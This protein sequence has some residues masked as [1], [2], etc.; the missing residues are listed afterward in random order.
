MPIIT[1]TLPV[2][3]KRER[4]TRREFLEYQR[5]LP[6]EDAP[7][8]PVTVDIDKQMLQGLVK[9][10]RTAVKNLIDLALKGR[11][12]GSEG[13]EAAAAVLAQHVLPKGLTEVVALDV[14]PQFHMIEDAAAEIPWEALE[15]NYYCCPNGHR[16]PA[17]QA[18]SGFVLHCEHDD[19]R[20]SSACSKLVLGRHVTHLVPR[21]AR[22]LASGNQFLFIAD[23]TGEL[24]NS[25]N[26][27]QGYCAE[28]LDTLRT[29]L[30]NRG[31]EVL[32][33]QEGNATRSAVLDALRKPGVVGVYYFGHG[34]VPTGRRQQGRLVLCD[35][36][37]FAREIEQA[38]SGASLVFLN[39]CEGAIIG[40]GWESD[41]EQR[42][43]SVAEGFAR[44]GGRVVIGTLWPVVN[45]QAARTAL[46]FFERILTGDCSIGEA[47]MHA[48][49]C[50]YRRYKDEDQPDIS[51]MSYRFF[52]DP[53][54]ILPA[55]PGPQPSP[56]RDVPAQQAQCRV[57][58]SQSQLDRETFAFAF[59][60]A[61]ACAAARRNAQGRARATTTDFLAGLM[62]KGDLTRF[63]LHEL[64]HDPDEA[65]RSVL[66]LP[67]EGSPAAE[68]APLISGRSDLTDELAAVFMA[69]DGRAQ[70]TGRAAE[71]T[72]ICERHMLDELLAAGA[73]SRLARL[74]LPSSD[75]MEAQLKAIAEAGE[76]DDNGAI[77]LF[78]LDR[79]ARRVMQAAHGYAQ[80]R[81]ICPITN[82][83]MLAALLVDDNGFAARVC[84]SP[85]VGI[86]PDQLFSMMIVFMEADRAGAET[87]E[88]G[89]PQQP[90]RTFGLSPEAC[91]RI[92]LPV[93]KEARRMAGSGQLVGDKELFRAFCDKA[94]SGFKLAMRIP[95]FPVDLDELATIDPPEI[96]LD[97]L[98]GRLDGRARRVVDTAHLLAKQRGD[99]PISNRLMLAAFLMEPGGYAAG[100]LRAQGIP[101]TQ[102][103]Q[104]LIAS[105]GS[106]EGRDFPL[107]F[108]AC[109]RIVLPMLKRADELASTET[110]VTE[111]VLFKA[112]CQVAASEM[113]QAV[114]APPL[115]IDLDALGRGDAS[116][117]ADTTAPACTEAVASSSPVGDSVSVR[118]EDFDDVAWHV[119]EQARL[120]AGKS[121]WP[122]VRTPHLA[123]ALLSDANGPAVAVL[124][125]RQID[126]EKA[127]QMVL[128]FVPQ[129]SPT[130]VENPVLGDNV[131]KTLQLAVRRAQSGQRAKAAPD[132]LFAAMAV[133]PN[134]PLM[135]VLQALSQGAVAAAF[136]ATAP[137]G[138]SV[139]ATLGVDLTE[140]ARRG[141]LPEIVGRDDE[142]DMA[143]QT[144]LLTENANPLLV[145]EAGI[146]KT[147]IVEGIAQRIVHGRC[148]RAL[149][150]KRIVELSAG[151]LVANTR[152]RGEFE[153]RVRD[154]LD[155]ARKG[156][157]LLF[158]DEIHTIVGAGVAEGGGPDAGNMLKSALARGEIR[159][160]GATTPAEY[161]RTI[162]RDKALSRRFQVQMLSPPSREATIGI[163]SARQATFEHCHGVKIADEAKIAAVDLSGRY[164]SDKQWPAKAR[165]VMERA[166][167]L[168][169]VDA[170]RAEAEG[171]VAVRPE[172]VAKV[173]ARLTGIPLERVSAVDMSLLSTL[174]QRLNARV[175][176]QQRAV[177]TVAGAIR[178]GRQGLARQKKPW[179]VFLFV[180]PPGVGKTELAKV[181]AEEVFGGS[182]GLIRFDMGD[183]SEAHSTARL[184]GAPPGY[185]GFDQGAPLVERLRTHPYS[186]VLFD[187]IEHAHENV[188][189]VLLRLLSEGTIA[190]AE[191]NVAD[192]TNSII[193][194]TS[195][196]LNSSRD[197][198]LGFEPATNS[199]PPPQ[200]SQ[201][202][203]RET[204]EQFLPAKLIDRLDAI[205]P[206]NSLAAEDFRVLAG[207]RVSEIVE[208]AASRNGVC[209]EVADDVLPWLAKA[210]A[211]RS[212]NARDVLRFVEEKVGR[213][214]IAA[215]SDSSLGP[216]H[217]LRI[218][219]RGDQSGVE[220]RPVQP[221]EKADAMAPPS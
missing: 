47:L 33:L 117:R 112:Y 43:R 206:F 185:V 127:R 27:Q 41:R 147:A 38:A 160:V 211:H 143:L 49:E 52:G 48:R 155:E 98:L 183:F 148:P 32:Y 123:A 124:R 15:E 11:S 51:W 87:E 65:Y 180:G 88:G 35:G 133:D 146:G 214:L 121:G 55:V 191:G 5:W 116:P 69:A 78:C 54:R 118:P 157:V 139:L 175:I 57:F 25:E 164:I 167:V 170:E 9:G 84:R 2:S 90:R 46:E 85:K 209:V 20:M 132:D 79:D 96:S 198:H 113:K 199:T 172:H 30:E 97:E 42:A 107:D 7:R 204:I 171:P 190:D 108:E 174:E 53:N 74:G 166:C 210:G 72:Q 68:G 203:L 111:E 125:E 140:K 21:D 208:Q 63:V 58:N 66:G 59:D 67:E 44:A 188:L 194:L 187:E 70:Q 23:P 110:A 22:P 106:G 200:Y 126:P 161:R 138:A 220:C 134:G 13:V 205:I 201:I 99:H 165:D 173:V 163:L 12:R 182:D 218:E 221:Q 109:K 216:G 130:A 95:P 207:K 45:A 152:L 195:N 151:G 181:M 101:A 197:R 17:G 122:E 141:E 120:I 94:D 73:W 24:C 19:L 62:S 1:Q 115:N 103:C 29:L 31:Y 178:M 77:D 159:L 89:T 150:D 162:A 3:F 93:I 82:R 56:V 10:V 153:Q 215:L 156:H 86:D 131:Q 168:A 144:L 119:V 184:V 213:A 142:I 104:A 137:D 91:D 145:G 169:S 192:A 34:L 154:V 6:Q 186:L 36:P 61:L 136:G 64:H 212:P 26:D 14:H 129:Q 193:I 39:A 114:K 128:S 158:I 176:G 80:Q 28:H 4:G 8:N 149:R 50:S 196:V 135:Q 179:G 92:V 18:G 16:A 105:T 177:S 189:A 71:A 40:E 81:G 37:L 76:V 202:E 83:L 100:L 219:V 102:L 75:A 217:S 60:E